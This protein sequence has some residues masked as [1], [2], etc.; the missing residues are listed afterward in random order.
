MSEPKFIVDLNAGRLVK[1][2]RIM[3]YDTA[4][5]P[6][7]EDGRLVSLAHEEGRILLTRDRNIMRRR[8]IASGILRAILLESERLEEQLRQ[9][10][11]ICNLDTQRGFSLCIECNLPLVKAAREEIRDRVPPYVFQTQDIIVKCP[12]CR[13]PFWRGTHWRNIRRR[14]ARWYAL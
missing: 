14:L 11:D 3:G 2:L 8:V 12:S 4:F 5:V 13:K 1:W 9:V 6:G 7:I 10:V